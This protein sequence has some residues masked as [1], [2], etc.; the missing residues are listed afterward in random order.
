MFAS[1]I[2]NKYFGFE[3]Q[4]YILFLES[5]EKHGTVGMAAGELAFIE[6][7]S[8]MG[9]VKGLVF[10]HY[11]AE[12]PSDLFHCLERFGKRHNIPVLCTDDFGHGMRHG[13][14]P[15]GMKAA[16][17]ADKQELVFC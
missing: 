12:P 10:G 17:D 2:A 15:I 16:L 5:H 6:Q 11:S 7:T 14:L 4:E 1:M 8:F 13:I 3:A 9:K